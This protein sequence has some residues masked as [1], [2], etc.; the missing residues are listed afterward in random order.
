MKKSDIFYRKSLISGSSKRLFRMK[1]A[2]A[3][4]ETEVLYFFA[5]F[6]LAT[7]SLHVRFMFATCSL[8]VRYMFASCSLHVRYM[9]ATCSL[10]VRFMFAS[11]SLHVRFMFATC[12]LHVRFM[13][14]TCS[15]YLNTCSL[16][17]LNIQLRARYISKPPE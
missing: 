7:C 5:K 8:H 2:S 10:H 15:L 14:A 16:H 11:C 17:V 13:F 1:R 6:A 4:G 9:F 3:F 12:S